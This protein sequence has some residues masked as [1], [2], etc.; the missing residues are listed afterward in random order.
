LPLIALCGAWLPVYDL[1]RF[2]R[3]TLAL[4][5]A[6]F[7]AYGWALR[8]L[9]AVASPATVLLV[10]AALRLLALP[11]PPTL[12]DDVLRYVW[13][14]KVATAGFNPYRWAPEAAE[15]SALRD[16][17]WR[18]M[19]HKEVPAVYPPAALALFSI[20][21][22]LPAPTPALKVLLAAADLAACALLLRLA[23]ALG[24]RP[25]RAAWYAWNPLVVLEVAGMG[26]VDALMVLAM[27]AAVFFLVRGAAW[28]SAAAAAL[29]VLA[30]LVP[31][32]ALPA[33]ARLSRRPAR[34]LALAG[35]LV[36][37]AFLPFVAALGGP[38]PGL[39]T[40]GVAWEWNGPLYEPLW[41]LYERLA[42]DLLLKDGLDELKELTG[43]HERWN[44]VYPFVYPQLLA[45]ATLAL[46]MLALIARS[47]RDRRPVI[48]TGR[49]F[50]GV[51]LCSAT[52]YPWYLLWVLPW[53]ALARHR[54]WLALSAL[55]QLSYLPQLTDLELVPWIYLLIWTPFA[56]LLIRSRWSI[57]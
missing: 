53:A 31:L 57:D 24:L 21:S 8:R 9:E 40:Y 46:V 22:V 49:L 39:V 3:L 29:A 38:P 47:W 12:S 44:H 7:A 6:A 25:G 50:G 15:L 27:V 16:D 23:T 5:L 30:K 51:L 4:V 1:A 18:R 13:D 41:R 17:D 34:F 28:R 56:W 10:A 45:K 33:W 54:A 26:H 48:A 55:V 35:L 42:L 37:A 14:G 52:L 32:V 43:W 2:P 11:L 36:A 19:P 20:A